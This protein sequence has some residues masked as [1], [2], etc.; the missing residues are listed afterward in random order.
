MEVTMVW[1]WEAAGRAAAV[2]AAGAAVAVAA[3]AA[4]ARARMAAERV[5]MRAASAAVAALEADW[6][7]QADEGAGMAVARLEE[8]AREAVRAAEEVT[9][10]EGVVMVAVVAELL[11]VALGVVLEEAVTAVREARAV[12][13][14]VRARAAEAWAEAVARAESGSAAHSRH[15]PSRRCTP[16]LQLR[17]LHPGTRRYDAPSR[18]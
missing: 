2:V 17:R 15:N 5:A 4:T 14:R 10:A 7:T 13:G 1:G 16:P 3:V 11:G 9:A 6:T 12:G 8:M 18:S